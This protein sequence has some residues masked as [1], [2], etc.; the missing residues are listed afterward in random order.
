MLRVTYFCASISPRDRFSQR[1]KTPKLVL[2]GRL[3]QVP[4]ARERRHEL[5]AGAGVL[6]Q[7]HRPTRGQYPFGN[8]S[9][10]QEPEEPP[11]AFVREMKNPVSVER[12]PRQHLL[13]APKHMTGCFL[14]R[15][16]RSRGAVRFR[17]ATGGS[18]S[19]RT[20]LRTRCTPRASS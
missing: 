20:R 3:Q 13:S 18:T 9:E 4:G 11:M 19:F 12:L 6:H 7:A 17:I 8:N 1:N 10:S 15:W 2:D 14:D 16:H 5:G